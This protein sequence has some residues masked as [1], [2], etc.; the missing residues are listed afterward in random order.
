MEPRTPRNDS[1]SF[2]STLPGLLT[3]IAGVLTAIATLVGALV[4]AG[5]IGPRPPA[6]TPNPTSGPAPSSTS[7]SPAEASINVAYTGDPLGC[8]LQLSIRIDGQTAQP[9]GTQYTIT[10]VPTGVQPYDIRGAISCTAAGVCQ[11]NGSGQIDVADGRTYFISW[12]NTA[13]G[14]CAVTLHP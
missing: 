14:A 12:L 7:P 11:A 2:W 9:T 6:P 13:V 4:A 1:P 3:A 8:L 10:N 5:V